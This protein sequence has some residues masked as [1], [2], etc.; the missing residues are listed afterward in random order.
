M[1][2]YVTGDTHSGLDIQKIYDWEV[3]PSL[4][5][6]DYLIVAGDFGYPWDFLSSEEETEISWLE[7]QPYT[8]LFVDGNHERYDHWAE[9][10]YEE[11]HG[12]TVQ[13]LRP[14]SPLRHLCRGEVYDLDGYKIFTMG[15]ATSVD[16]KWRVPYVDWWPQE[17]PDEQD[18]DNA[19]KNLDAAGWKVDYVIT[20]TCSNP[21]LSKALYPNLGWESPDF[22]QLTEFLNELEVKLDFKHWY[23]GHMHRDRDCDEKHTLLYNEIVELGKG[24]DSF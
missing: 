2:I 18:F 10:P 5:R 21:M 9:R 22:D 3:G 4:T 13:R 17:M 11:W 15:G 24:I 6:K 23:F 20:H 8:L 1:A 7:R 16:K 12:G 19:R 14:K